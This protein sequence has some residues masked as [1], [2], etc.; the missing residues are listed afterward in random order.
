M[1]LCSQKRKRAFRVLILSPGLEFY[2]L[3]IYLVCMFFIFNIKRGTLNGRDL[4]Q[5]NVYASPYHLREDVTEY[6]NKS[7]VEEIDSIDGI[8][9]FISDLQTKKL[10]VEAG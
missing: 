10:W 4:A 9:D 1:A 8:Y 5:H 6:F 7:R 2:L 3:F